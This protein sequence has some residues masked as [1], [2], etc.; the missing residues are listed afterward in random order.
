MATTEKSTVQTTAKITAA[1]IVVTPTR[2]ITVTETAMHK[3][4]PPPTT[5]EPT[6]KP[7]GINKAKY[8]PSRITM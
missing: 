3:T 6:H 4:I 2:P 8:L 5:A 1:P 7:L